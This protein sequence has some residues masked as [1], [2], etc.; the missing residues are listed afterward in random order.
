[1]GIILAKFG[2]RG[3][4]SK[5]KSVLSGYHVYG[6]DL[7]M[8]GYVIPLEYP[9]SRL[10]ELLGN[11]TPANMAA[12]CRINPDVLEELLANQSV[13]P[14]VSQLISISKAYNVSVLWLLGYHTAKERRPFDSWDQAMIS[15]ISSR[16]EAEHTLQQPPRGK[17]TQRIYLSIAQRRVDKASRKIAALAAEITQKEHYPLS[18]RDLY[19]YVGMPV[20]VECPGA[21]S[22]WGVIRDDDIVTCKGTFPIEEAGKRYRAFLMPT[23]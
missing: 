6:R 14:S 18:P 9:S 17:F 23:A 1:M 16:N 10:Y 19:I 13:E 11:D 4:S 2:R 8:V 15:A 22:Q 7:A 12:R 21:A 3:Q 20:L 5:G